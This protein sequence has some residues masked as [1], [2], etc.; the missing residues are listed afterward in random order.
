MDHLTHGKV[1]EKLP[2]KY[3]GRRTRIFDSLD[4]PSSMNLQS[5]PYVIPKAVGAPHLSESLAFAL[6]SG[7]RRD[8]HSSL[9]THCTGVQTTNQSVSMTRKK[10]SSAEEC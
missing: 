1:T 8:G 2:C 6:I 9:S 4:S 3:L 7:H 10:L 5:Q